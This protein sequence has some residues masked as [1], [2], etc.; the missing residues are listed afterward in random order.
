M[1]KDLELYLYLIERYKVFNRKY[2]Y[3]RSVEYLSDI[4]LDR[5]SPVLN[6]QKIVLNLTQTGLL[7]NLFPSAFIKGYFD[8][9]LLNFLSTYRDRISFSFK[10]T[11]GTKSRAGQG[12]LLQRITITNLHESDR[13]MVGLFMANHLDIYPRYRQQTV[14]A[15]HI[16]DEKIVNVEH[17]KNPD[18]IN[19]R[20]R[21]KDLTLIFEFY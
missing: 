3:T 2:F 8:D 5:Q 6:G 20:S 16:E 10:D 4:V 19:R 14:N 12:L 9:T 15:K 1:K 21:Y 7:Y 13:E 17:F 11:R 18:F